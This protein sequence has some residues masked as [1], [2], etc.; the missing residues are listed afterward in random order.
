[1]N[2]LGWMGLAWRPYP[3]IPR[4]ASREGN[5]S[6]IS[7]PAT[8]RSLQLK[9]QKLPDPFSLRLSFRPA[10]LTRRAGKCKPSSFCLFSSSAAL[11][12]TH[13]L[14]TV[15]L[16]NL[17]T[18]LKS[19]S[20]SHS[21]RFFRC[22]SVLFNARNPTCLGPSLSRYHLLAVARAEPVHYEFL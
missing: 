18:C 17:F 21:V 12:Y 2:G 15:R 7:N 8:R 3:H 13:G 22:F 19:L 20:K 6:R 16:V 1:M 10:Q 9:I 4:S 11:H 14:V 5:Q